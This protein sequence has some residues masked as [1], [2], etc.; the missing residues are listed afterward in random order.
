MVFPLSVTLGIF[1]RGRC[2]DEKGIRSLGQCPTRFYICAPQTQPVD[3]WSRDLPPR[4]HVIG[5]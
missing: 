4:S 2:L 5:A 3:I 1:K